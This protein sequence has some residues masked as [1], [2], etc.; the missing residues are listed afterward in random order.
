MRGGIKFLLLAFLTAGAFAC[1]KTLEVNAPW[2]EITIVYG[3][4]NQSDTIHYV[5]ITKAFLGPGNALDYA[6]IADSSNYKL[7]LQV[8]LNEYSGTQMLRSLAL[9]DT[10]ITDK[11]SGL[12]YFPDQ[13]VYYTRSQLNSANSYKLRIVNTQTGKQMES[14]T[15]LVSNFTMSKP[16][17]FYGVS[18]VPGKSSLVQWISAPGGKRYQLTI[19]IQYSELLYGDSA[20]TIHYINWIPFT[21]VK[22][23]TDKGGQNMLFSIAG[24]DFYKFLSLNL[25]V[26]PDI[27]RSVGTCK[28]GFLV[29]SENLDAYMMVSPVS[30][31]VVQ[32]RI[33]FTNIFNGI[34]LFASRHTVTFDSLWFS[35][36]TKDSLKTN[37]YTK[38]LGF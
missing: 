14:D 13:K 30:N 15:K 6:K 28:Y 2:Q 34:G 10:V 19:T 25:A 31:T 32:T 4:L 26:N 7:P 5:K 18:F 35:N 12:F 21:E 33:P 37:R 38:E 9:K 24:E 22:S 11:D 29:G 17:Y 8:S 27:Q 36:V 1:K 3:I 16:D 23:I 20:K